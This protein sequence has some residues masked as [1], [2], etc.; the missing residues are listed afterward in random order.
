MGG[1]RAVR[2]R[3]TGS[4]D[5]A[6]SGPR[7]SAVRLP[8]LSEHP[9]R[10]AYAALARPRDVN[11]NVAK[12]GAE[13]LDELAA[14]TVTL[15]WT[16]RCNQRCRY[17]AVRED[18]TPAA[19][20]PE[21]ELLARASAALRGGFRKAFLVGGE[22]T[23]RPGL[24]AFVRR[25]RALGLQ[26]VALGTNAVA[27]AD[28]GRV[29]RLV[30]AGVDAFSVSLDSADPAVQAFL[31][32]NPANAGLVAEAAAA[33]AGHAHLVLLVFAL[34]CRQTQDGLERLVE[35]VDAL[36][37]RG[38]ARVALALT[39]LKPVGA[40]ARHPEL[41]V[42]YAEM[43]PHWEAAVARARRLAVPLIDLNLPP[44]V[45][46]GGERHR[47]EHRLDEAVW[48]ADLEILFRDPGYERSHVRLPTC[49]DC[50]FDECPGVYRGYVERW[51]DGEFA[52]RRSRARPSLRARPRRA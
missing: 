4:G 7:R 35:Y 30:D 29:A 17:C 15:L 33:I 21:D 27:L 43:R 10:G 45:F 2:S 23:V 37:A 19:Q 49:S 3:A 18:A 44:C 12:A 52:A 28:P 47:W 14:G 22:P 11:V 32:R 20:T 46:P 36:R 6:R 24:A 48:N 41:H 5:G 40:A 9:Q 39:G 26:H 50:V 38:R 31:T 13:L 42:R 16:P 8:C 34:I 25:L 1:R 51:G